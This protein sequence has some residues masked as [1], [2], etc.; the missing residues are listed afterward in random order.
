MK[1]YVAF[2]DTD[3][4]DCGR[5][6][7]KLA[8]WFRDE[9]PHDCSLLGVVRQQL[10]EDPSIPM[11]SHNSSLCD[12][13]EA[14]DRSFRDI[15]IDKAAKHIKNNFFE[16]SDPGLCV[17]C[18]NDPGLDK[19]IDFGIRCTDTIVTQKEAIEAAGDNHLSGHGGD[20]GGIIGAT[21]AIG[22]TIY[23]KSGRFVDYKKIRETPEQCTVRDLN[24][25][26]IEVMSINRHAELPRPD[27]FVDNR[28]S[29][30]PRLWGQNVIVPVI[31][32]G[33]NTWMII[34]DKKPGQPGSEK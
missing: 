27:D 2:D 14:P 4:L 28:G 1:I 19:L 3:T 18:E 16:G 30:R 11:T 20:N 34:K 32:T 29:L 8:R 25:M 17:Y 9:L 10:L 33:P 13:I 15:L 23:A 24:S 31:A 22:L 21:A 6:T 26:G 7:G 12:I 5:G